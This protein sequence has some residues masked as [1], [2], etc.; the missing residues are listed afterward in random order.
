M[1]AVTYASIQ[2]SMFC[3]FFTQ[4]IWVIRTRM[5]LDVNKGKAEYQ[6]FV[7]KTREI[8]AQN[9]IKGFG[10][11]LLLSLVLSFSGVVQMYFYEAFK[12]IYDYS[13]LPQSV[14]QQKSFVCGGASKI[15]SILL[16]YPITTVRT[17]I[18]QNQFFNNR[19][20]AKYYN[21]MDV[22]SRMIK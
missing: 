18:Q 4:P 20:N 2:A 9:G 11:G 19:N 7:E 1:D 3:T 6:N 5:F 21:L 22:T 16:S 8:F 14:L 15:W 10:K 17:R 13:E 12:L